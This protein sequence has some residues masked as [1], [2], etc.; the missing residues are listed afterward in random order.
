MGRRWIS[1]A[2]LGLFAFQ[3]VGLD[4]L[5]RG[6]RDLGWARLV[7]MT[8]SVLLLAL[9]ATCVRQ[10]LLRA[11]VALFAGGLFVL[12]AFAIRYYHAPFDL[13]AARSARRAWADV[14]PALVHVLPYFALAA[15]VV[16]LVEWLLLRRTPALEGR[17]RLPAVLVTLSAAACAPPLDQGTPETRALSMGAAFFEERETIPKGTVALP[18]LISAKANVP[19]VLVVITESIRATDYCKGPNEPCED[20]PTVHALLP[21]RVPLREMRSIASYTTISL[22]AIVT[23]QPQ[24]AKL[25]E[26][27]YMPTIW[28][29]AQRVPVGNDHV[30]AG[31]WTAHLASGVFDRPNM[32]EGMTREVSEETLPALVEGEPDLG[33]DHRIVDVFSKDIKQMRGPT[34]AVLHLYGTHVP[35]AFDDEK[36]VHTPFRRSVTW[37]TLDELHASYLN[38]IRAQDPE[39]ARGIQAFLDSRGDAPW[40]IVFTSD[41]GEAFGEHHA[42]HH[43]QNLYDE[44]IHVPAFIAHSAGLLTDTEAQHLRAAET[45]PTSHVDLL[46]TV[47]DVL[48]V[49]DSAAL[50]PFRDRMVGRSLLGPAPTAPRAIPMTS[51][52]ESFPCPQNTW[53]MLGDHHA[54][55]AQ[56]WDGGFH[57]VP[58]DD[59][60]RSVPWND[61]C[62]ELRAKSWLVFPLLPNGNPNH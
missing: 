40:M 29:L 30:Q 11:L 8:A 35:Y 62:D 22:G 43:G 51:C 42:I 33:L 36:A 6:S 54:L 17:R 50:I 56:T 27:A 2:A 15:A 10:R 34:V 52:N 53:G 5:A 44:Q 60:G 1:R 28:D 12:Q 37:D 20:A 23:S 61:E 24:T 19:S 57:C 39:I 48:G 45:L 3:F 9:L 55:V 16:G 58:L 13:Q 46:P 59:S 32:A 18:T 31:Y 14:G 21:D 49:W 38:A 26:L 4:L 47:L 7:S 25:G 41:H